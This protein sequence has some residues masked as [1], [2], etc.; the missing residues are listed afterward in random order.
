MDARE[1]VRLRD[2]LTVTAVFAAVGSGGLF[3]YFLV[4]VGQRHA[5]TWV[6]VDCAAFTVVNLASLVRASRRWRRRV[7]G[8]RE[9]QAIRVAN[10]DAIAV[11]LTSGGLSIVVIALTSVSH[12]RTAAVI[13][14][15]VALVVIA[16]GLLV[17]GSRGRRHPPVNRDSI[18]VGTIRIVRGFSLIFAIFGFVGLLDGIHSLVNGLGNLHSTLILTSV[19]GIVF[20]IC[21]G[22][23]G[24]ITY[25]WSQR[26]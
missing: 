7:D 4:L 1:T 5:A 17:F 26:R 19:S 24:W 15:V 12:E 3:T 2:Q 16:C 18:S 23:F 11:F 25:S 13:L 21:A 6:A 14:P 9:L 22:T 10:R 20:L 8:T